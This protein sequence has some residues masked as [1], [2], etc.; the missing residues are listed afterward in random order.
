MDSLKMIMFQIRLEDE[1]VFSFN[2][3]EEMADIFF[4]VESVCKYI[5]NR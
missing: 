2:P 1:F 3:M 5:E 4:S